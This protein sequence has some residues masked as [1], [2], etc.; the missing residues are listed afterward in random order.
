MNLWTVLD[1][2]QAT[3][4][5]NVAVSEVRTHAH[6]QPRSERLLPYKDAGRAKLLSDDHIQVLSSALDVSQEVE[7]EPIWLADIP[8][9]PGRN[10]KAGLYVVDGHHRLSAY[11]K[12]ERK[13]IPARILPMNFAT[14]VLV[15][16]PINCSG[17][18][19]LM[20]REQ[21]LDATWQYL[22]AVMERGAR[23]FLPHGESLRSV[24]GKFGVGHQT[25][26]RM[27]VELRKV[28]LDEYLPDARDPGTDWPRW[29]YVRTPKSIWQTPIEMLPNEARIV[30]NAESLARAIAGMMENSSPEE[31]ALALQM[32]AAEE[33]SSIDPTETVNF[34]AD[35]ARPYGTYVEYVLSHWDRKKASQA[36]G[37]SQNERFM[38][39]AAT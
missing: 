5:H 23:P 34:L 37:L 21:R 17:C 31:R 7:L 15:S 20:H 11:N 1:A 2:M 33:V 22:A 8:A 26:S 13:T 4:V 38:E 16:K 29:K 36:E 3:E 27:L 10:I 18:K 9:T 12:A 39:T 24:A 19:L 28:R 30:R 25:V 35:A 6:L 14:A 32:L